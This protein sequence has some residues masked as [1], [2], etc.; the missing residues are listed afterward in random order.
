MHVPVAYYCIL[1]YM[2]RYAC[3]YHCIRMHTVACRHH[4]VH[5][6]AYVTIHIACTYI[7]AKIY[8]FTLYAQSNTA[9][10]LTLPLVCSCSHYVCRQQ[11][12]HV[13]AL[14]NVFMIMH[15]NAAVCK[16]LAYA[17]VCS[18]LCIRLYD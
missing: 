6:L 5:Q 3:A 17:Y 9:A 10:S 13:N 2:Q 16:T 4:P 7:L 12:M 1:L 18:A 14:S 8:T 11:H 15:V